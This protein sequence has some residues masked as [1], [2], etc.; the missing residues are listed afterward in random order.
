MILPKVQ[1]I[2]VV[3]L[4]EMAQRQFWDFYVKNKK[5]DGVGSRQIVDLWNSFANSVNDYVWYTN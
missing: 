3:N 5:V 1:G 2:D 4:S